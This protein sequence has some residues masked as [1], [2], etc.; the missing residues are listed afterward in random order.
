[1]GIVQS[2]AEGSVS[3][4][5]IEFIEVVHVF[6]KSTFHRSCPHFTRG[7]MVSQAPE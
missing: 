6:K 4:L 5:V 3:E 2:R 1:M 7:V